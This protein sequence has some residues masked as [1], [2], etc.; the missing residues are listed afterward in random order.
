MHSVSND[1]RGYVVGN[2]VQSGVVT[3]AAAASRPIAVAGLPAQAVFVG[4]EGE[5]A[6]LVD[7][8]RPRDDAS[9]AV[10]VWSVAGLPG[11]GKTALAVRAAH[12]AVASGWFPGGVVMANMRGYD[13]P[14]QC[15]PASTALV[16]LLGA[17]GVPSEHI[18]PEL[19]DR[20][21]L[22]RS[23]LAE[24][25]A[26]G[27]RMLVIA[28]NVSDPDKV[29]P[30]L[31]GTSAH[32]VLITSRHRLAQLDGARLL[33]L[34]VLDQEAAV[35]MLS[36]VVGLSNP[37]DGRA[38]AEPDSTRRVARLCGGLPLAVRVAAA[39]LVAEPEQSMA[40][41]AE[42]LA[43]GR[44]RL[45][46]LRYDGSLSVRAAF[47]LS[48]AHL[49]P[50]QARLFRLMTLDP[51]PD[52]GTPA[53]AAIAGTDEAAARG[54]L[55]Q[56][57]RAHLVRPGSAADR[58]RTHD[59]L[60]LYGAEKAAD[61]NERDAATVRLFEHYLHRVRAA[62]A[63]IA[64]LAPRFEPGA[65]ACF[66]TRGEALA[67][68]DTE[69]ANVTAVIE[70]AATSGHPRYAI[71]L[72]VGMHDYFDLRKYWAAWTSTHELALRCAERLGDHAAAGTLLVNL[73]L[74][75][76]QLMRLDEAKTAHQRALRI[77]RLTNDRTGFGRALNNLGSVLRDLGRAELAMRCHRW[78]LALF[79]EAHHVQHECSALH[80]IAVTH[81]RLGHR[82]VAV[83]FYLQNLVNLRRLGKPLNVGRT[84][85]L[86]GVVYRELGRTREAIDCHLGNLAVCDELLDSHG[87]ARGNANLAVTYRAAGRLPEATACH[88]TALRTFRQF[89][90]RYQEGDEL[91]E[92][93]R[94]HRRAGRYA[95]ASRCWAEALGIFET[96]PGQGAALA[97][98]TRT[99][100]AEI[101][102]AALIVLSDKRQETTVHYRDEPIHA[103]PPDS[104]AAL[105]A[106]AVAA[107]TVAMIANGQ[108]S[109]R[110][111][112]LTALV[113]ELAGPDGGSVTEI[114]LA[115]DVLA[116]ADK[117]AAAVLAEVLMSPPVGVWLV[118]VLRRLR[119]AATDGPDMAVEL[120]FLGSI[121][122]AVAIRTNTPCVLE[123]AAFDGVVTL[124]TVGQVRFGSG[125]AT[126]TV[127]PAGA[128]VR[129][130]LPDG[131]TAACEVPGGAEF[132]PA[133]RLALVGS[134]ARFEVEI[135]DSTPY[136]E[137]SAPVPPRPLTAVELGEWTA[138]LAH[139]WDILTRW[140]ARFA[141]EIAAGVTALTPVP[142]ERGIV[143]ASSPTAYG[144]VAVS[145]ADSAESLAATLVHELQHS[146]LNGLGELVRLHTDTS[147]SWY[148][149]WRDDPR[150]LSGVL[151]GVYA[152]T[153]GAEFWDVQ[154]H[155]V[156]STAARRATFH[157]AYHHRQVRA[158]IDGIRS[159]ADLTGL[160]QELVAAAAHRLR[161]CAIDT[162]PAELDEPIT[163]VMVEH[164]ATWRLR[165]LRPDTEYAADV[166][167]AWC[168][169]APA[170]PARNTP[171]TVIPF[172]RTVPRSQRAPLLTALVV[173]SVEP[174]GTGADVA[175][176]CG[177]YDDAMDGYAR[178]LTASPDDG[179]AWV[180]MGLT[181]RAAGDA[182]T[183]QVFLDQAEDT[184]AAWRRL[185]RDV[186]TPP[187]PVEFGRWLAGT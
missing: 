92:L 107:D 187:A 20:A 69:H 183:A 5:L 139:A 102:I 42:A 79:R 150:P 32:R 58:W 113:S 18:P 14:G 115:W 133:R 47:D 76:R 41:L 43:D 110:R 175:F 111:L 132:V 17:L 176:A 165:H 159:S 50:P 10:V 97:V 26:K 158:A 90:P 30:L 64:Y 103:V 184:S 154:R 169:R 51:G 100:L 114:E 117:H 137:F 140:H 116:S 182:R 157:F 61:D 56:L 109:R 151:H 123:V 15:V 135:D 11:V 88:V 143:G 78:A 145:M 74:M 120:G 146:K 31:P 166:V 70:L 13:Q 185:A 4:R 155:H 149:P 77:F 94:T 6:R 127:T 71:E 173:D 156:P 85:D 39:L 96:L 160:G 27:L 84:L 180:G 25:A 16:G 12:E 83:D 54:L 59:L 49:E 177:L 62:Y 124:P 60:R 8:L 55:R 125:S 108:Y 36:A 163:T 53:I 105:I 181:L 178:R 19:A 99:A 23:M 162:V 33:D 68:L 134:G 170:P 34:D 87:A 153:S 67:W 172:Q 3:I 144:S 126:L 93:G 80:N 112:L 152:F 142:A 161:Q 98:R 171:L 40:E 44:N 38:A 89:G 136:R 72:A 57:R 131:T 9:A 35:R 122:G 95:D 29:L 81:R 86:L 1:V 148:T 106:G 174:S 28:D 164:R 73:G 128:H 22:W 129:M 66:A 91:V 7:A 121:A 118:R 147:A 167:S 101:D 48:Y 104:F 2:V 37:G 63:H 24:R 186:R 75:Y 138:R 21:W 179:D 65:G 130:S 46:E 141:V 82:R 45:A 52:T 168:A 119:G